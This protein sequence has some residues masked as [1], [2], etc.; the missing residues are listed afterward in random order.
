MEIKILEE[1]KERLKIEIVGEGNTI[2]NPLVKEL[3]NDE[4]IK[5]AGYRIEHSLVSNPILIVET[6]GVSAKEALKKAGSRLDKRMNEL[7]QKFK[8]AK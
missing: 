4:H 5:A 1:S 8:Q 6:D 7:K 2:A 3:W